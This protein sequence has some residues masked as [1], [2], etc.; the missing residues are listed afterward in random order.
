[1]DPPRHRRPRPPR[2]RPLPS[3][4]PSWPPAGAEPLELDD[5]YERLA[6]LGLDYGPAFQGLSAAWQRG[7]GALRRGRAGRRAGRGSRALRGPPGAARRGPARGRRLALAGRRRMSRPL[8]FAWSGVR[9]SAAGA[10]SL[11][12]A[13]LSRRRDRLAVRDRPA[14]RR[15]LGRLAARR[16][17]DRP[18][19]VAGGQALASDRVEP[20]APTAARPTPSLALSASSTLGELEAERYPTWGRCWTAIAAAQRAP[21]SSSSTLAPPRREARSAPPTPWPQRLDSSRR[22]LERRATAEPRA[23][24]SHRG[25]GGG[26]RGRRPPTSPRAALGPGPLGPGRAPRPLRPDRQRRQRG[27]RARRSPARPARR[28]TSP[29]SPCARARRWCPAWPRP[30]PAR[31]G[32]GRHR[33]TPSAPS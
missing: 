19:S 29:S 5:L 25:R 1:M 10:S 2:L 26:Q 24:S 23:W 4:S 3:R 14:V 7:R 21:T 17:V 15:R 28:A 12:V 16:P 30:R 13:R 8:P 11:R 22:W 31:R 18:S 32:A 6:E 33:S 20:L 9:V 27:L